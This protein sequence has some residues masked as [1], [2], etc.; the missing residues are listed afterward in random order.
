M[1]SNCVNTFVFFT[2]FDENLLVKHI[3]FKYINVFFQGYYATFDSKCQF[4][5][6]VE[7]FSAVQLDS[8]FDERSDECCI[9]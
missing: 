8:V 7:Q 4:P 2:D 3:S 9:K 5:V 1:F 6:R